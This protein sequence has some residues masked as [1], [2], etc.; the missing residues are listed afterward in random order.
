MAVSAGGRQSLRAGLGGWGAGGGWCHHLQPALPW[1]P[2]ECWAVGGLSNP[3]AFA[4][5]WSFLAHS[6]QKPGLKG[7]PVV[8]LGLHT[9][10]LRNQK[11]VTK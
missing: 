8:P 3:E 4:D 5:L 2:P 7:G 11:D 1:G 10:H 9:G 6:A